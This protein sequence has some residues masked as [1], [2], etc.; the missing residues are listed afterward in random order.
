MKRKYIKL[1]IVLSAQ[2]MSNSKIE[3]KLALKTQASKKGYN[4]YEEL[5]DSRI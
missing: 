1:Y 2:I 4:I 3:H 5:S